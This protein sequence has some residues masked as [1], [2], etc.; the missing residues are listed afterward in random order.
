MSNSK[1]E[2]LISKLQEIFSE[3]YEEKK[4]LELFV[5]DIINIRKLFQKLKEVVERFEKRGGMVDNQVDFFKQLDTLKNLIEENI[6]KSTQ[7]HGVIELLTHYLSAIREDYKIIRDSVQTLDDI[8]KKIQRKLDKKLDKNKIAKLL[9]R[10]VEEKM[11][12][13]ILDSLSQDKKAN[14]INESK[15]KLDIVKVFYGYF[16]NNISF[17]RELLENIFDDSKYRLMLESLQSKL[18]SKE[19]NDAIDYFNKIKLR[20]I[21]DRGYSTEILLNSLTKNEVFIRSVSNNSRKYSQF[22]IE[23]FQKLKKHNEDDKKIIEIISTIL[24]KFDENQFLEFIKSIFEDEKLTNLV[25]KTIYNRGIEFYMAEFSKQK[26]KSH[27]AKALD[28]FQ[29]TSE[30]NIIKLKRLF[31]RMFTDLNICSKTK[32]ITLLSFIRSSVIDEHNS[33]GTY[34]LLGEIFGLRIKNLEIADDV[35][36]VRQLFHRLFFQSLQYQELDDI[37]SF[38]L[39][40]LLLFYIHVEFN[41]KANSGNRS[42]E[43]SE[44]EDD[45]PDQEMDQESEEESEN[46]SEEDT[47]QEHEENDELD[48]EQFKSID[49]ILSKSNHYLYKTNTLSEQKSIRINTNLKYESAEDSE[50][51]TVQE[52]DHKLLILELM[53]D[54][55]NV[56]NTEYNN[57]ILVEVI[58]VLKMM[59]NINSFRFRYTCVRS[60]LKELIKGNQNESKRKNVDIF[61]MKLLKKFHSKVDDKAEFIIRLAESFNINLLKDIVKDRKILLEEMCSSNTNFDCYIETLLNL[62]KNFAFDVDKNLTPGFSIPYYLSAKLIEDNRYKNFKNI[63]TVIVILFKVFTC[64]VYLHY[65]TI[66]QQCHVYLVQI[67][68]TV[69]IS[70]TSSGAAV[71]LNTG[72][73]GILFLKIPYRYFIS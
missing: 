41:Q 70:I 35:N 32:Q 1:T 63:K 20:L 15:L 17:V 37:E 43:E 44:S 18:F 61:K 33:N 66:I 49:K 68:Q 16:I 2:T 14:K 5:E 47:D 30:S 40:S 21:N 25:F 71:Y 24:F 56:K 26:N 27:V 7:P 23:I 4:K 6:K 45:E 48:A 67:N 60:I 73:T 59:S 51:E 42:S 53:R 50:E 62:D 9:I 10:G 58:A 69:L 72:I 12:N 29:P 8:N 64:L 19:P 34:C 13:Y 28:Y 57:N 36:A 65:T 39:F 11:P 54:F 3:N 55:R 38:P 52:T 22:I 46:E 31:L